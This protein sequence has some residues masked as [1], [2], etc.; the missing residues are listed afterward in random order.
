MSTAWVA[1]GVRS[2]AMKRRRI[3]REA[4]RRLAASA[5]LDDALAALVSGP[6]GH[7]LRVGQSLAEAQR[8]VVASMVWNLRVLAGWAPR[9]GVLM[10]R[11]FTAAIEIA[12]VD[13]HLQVLAGAAAPAPYVLGALSTAWPRLAETSNVA[14]LRSALATSR[15]GDPGSNDPHDIAVFLRLSLAGRI[16][17]DLP[18]AR[19][20][21]AGAAALVL[22]RE[23]AFRRAAPPDRARRMASRTV[24]RIA[25]A[26]GSLPELASQLPTDARW[27][28]A[29]VGEPNDLWRAEIGW[30]QRVD[31]DATAMA[32]RGVTESDVLLGATARL[33]VDA[34]RVR[35]ALEV[36][37]RGNGRSEDFDAVA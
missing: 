5:S 30:W 29:D 4:A 18:L 2:T 19:P 32:K 34:W 3:G 31:R 11:A 12:N 33:A 17:T 1:V 22:A 15:W 7:E 25:A 14:E 26:A 23:V 16:L 28:L 24:G 36:A 20:W 13:D 8:A 10:L 6:Y 27:A 37:A 9:T 35:A 21:A